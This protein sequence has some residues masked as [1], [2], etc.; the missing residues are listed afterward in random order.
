[1]DGDPGSEEARPLPSLPTPPPRVLLSPP[2][3]PP[4][5]SVPLSHSFQKHPP[6][7]FP[8]LSN[9]PVLDP[10]LL[11]PHGGSLQ[12]SSPLP[13]FCRL[14]I[15]ILGRPLRLSAGLLGFLYFY[16]SRFACFVWGLFRFDSDTSL[17]LCLHYIG[18]GQMRHFCDF[19]LN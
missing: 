3:M 19:N 4:A 18:D 7:M 9:S 12:P 17:R 1:M 15:S 8:V 10:A 2:A 6:E 5:L 16:S 13:T 11:S 14:S